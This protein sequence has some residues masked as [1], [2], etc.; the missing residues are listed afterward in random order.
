MA[1]GV[2]TVCAVPRSDEGERLPSDIG[3]STTG[4]AGP[5]PDPQTGQPAGTVWV[6]VSSSR[7]DRALSL[8][9]E[10]DREDIRKATVS[11]ALG[12]LVEELAALSE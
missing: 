4:V 9:L 6:G 12:L 11:A 10:G 2:R 1:R 5:D 7:G 3:L 8:H